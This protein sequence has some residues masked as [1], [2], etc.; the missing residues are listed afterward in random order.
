MPQLMSSAHGWPEMTLYCAG[1][2][3]LHTLAVADVERIVYLL[4]GPKQY[5]IGDPAVIVC[6]LDALDSSLDQRY[7]NL[8]EAAISWRRGVI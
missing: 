5:P 6:L 3:V 2:D 7:A 1:C 8:V 4:T